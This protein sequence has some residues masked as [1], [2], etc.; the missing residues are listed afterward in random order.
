MFFLFTIHIIIHSGRQ[1]ESQFLVKIEGHLQ[2]EKKPI[3]DSVEIPISKKSDL[4]YEMYT[5][6]YTENVGLE[7]CLQ[8]VSQKYYTILLELR[9]RTS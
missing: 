6:L 9:T 5:V 4:N 2:E 8:A 7:F 1:I 3:C